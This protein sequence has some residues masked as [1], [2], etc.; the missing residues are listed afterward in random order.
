MGSCFLETHND[1]V[2]VYTPQTD[3]PS[4]GSDNQLKLAVPYISGGRR[5]K[6]V[7]N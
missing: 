7:L 5:T 6:S 4:G 3:R 2:E 1:R